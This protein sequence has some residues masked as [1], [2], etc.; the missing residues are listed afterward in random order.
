MPTGAPDYFKR[1]LLYGLYTADEPIAAYITDDGRFVFRLEDWPDIWDEAAQVGIAEL[2]AS[3]TPAKRWDRRGQ[4]LELDDFTCGLGRV[5][6]DLSGTGAA[7]EMDDA[8][9]AFGGYSCKLTGGAA[10]PG[11]A[12]IVYYLDASVVN[13]LGLEFWFRLS[14]NVQLVRIQF[15]LHDGSNLHNAS[16]RYNVSAQ[17]WQYYSSTPAWVSF[18][19]GVK[20]KP[21]YTMFHPVK[22][23]FDTTTRKYTRFI[24]A[25]GVVDMSAFS[26][27]VGG[28][29]ADPHL[30]VFIY[31][32]SDDGVNGVIH[33]DNVIITQNEPE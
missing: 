2:I 3:L 10:S 22:V 30:E 9:Y 6:T 15:L 27:Y 33:V 5:D 19:T 26:Y 14:S 1:I 17:A 28:S 7:V 12:A 21:G 29:D 23:V 4:I 20:V 18:V 25:G 13:R 16:V 32:V 24:Y 31:C 8:Y 11:H